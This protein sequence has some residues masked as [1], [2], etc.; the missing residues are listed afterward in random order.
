VLQVVS[1]IKT[2]TFS[3]AE[4]A[5]WVDITSF[6]LSITPSNSSN[7]I[8]VFVNIGSCGNSSGGSRSAAFRLM[9]N[10]TAIGV[11]DAAG[12]RPQAS[13]RIWNMNDTNHA[14]GGSFSFLDSPSTTSATT[15]KFQIL[16]QDAGGTM[17]IN[18][19]G[20]DSD[21]SESYQARTASTITAMEIA[22]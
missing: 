5:G 10:S 21:G 16:P 13:T 14:S 19:T 18:R 20:A 4:N 17:Y 11:G 7:K 1:T 6:S 3:A 2:D 22:G 9:R 8:L 15:Y 12:S